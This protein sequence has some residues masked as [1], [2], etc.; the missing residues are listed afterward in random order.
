VIREICPSLQATDAGN[1]VECPGKYLNRLI[2][3]TKNIFSFSPGR[4][5]QA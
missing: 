3:A 4:N 2:L 5:L 1:P